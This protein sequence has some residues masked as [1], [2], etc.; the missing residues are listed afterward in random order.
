VTFS[1]KQISVTFTLA[2]GSFNGSGGA[3]TVT[4]T[5]LGG[6]PD[7][8]FHVKKKAAASHRG[9]DTLRYAEAATFAGAV[10]NPF[11]PRQLVADDNAPRGQRAS[12]NSRR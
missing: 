6:A 8:I 4:Y 1:K 2:S 10:P 12:R 7:G 9:P 3:N 11:V 5:D